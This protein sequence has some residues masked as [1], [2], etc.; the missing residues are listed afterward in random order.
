MEIL[1][2][3]ARSNPNSVA[4]AIA[5]IYREKKELEI[6]TIGAGSLNQ[7]IKAVAIARGFLAP[8]GEDI[9]LIPAFNEV[10]INGENKTALKLLVQKK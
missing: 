9:V 6:Q 10:I 2:V 7:A 5:N 1:K 8:S 4:G 3:S